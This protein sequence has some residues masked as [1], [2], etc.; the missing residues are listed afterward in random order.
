MIIVQG[1]VEGTL[2]GNQGRWEEE[3]RWPLHKTDEG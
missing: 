2:G 3:V 1:V